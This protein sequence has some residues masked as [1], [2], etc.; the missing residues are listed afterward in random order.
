M[1]R[2]NEEALGALIIQLAMGSE[3]YEHTEKKFKC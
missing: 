1:T 3:S 2:N